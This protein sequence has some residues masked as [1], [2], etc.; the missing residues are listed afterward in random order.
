LLVFTTCAVGYQRRA[1]QMVIMIEISLAVYAASH[2]III[3]VI[4]RGVLYG[5]VAVFVF[6][7]ILPQKEDVTYI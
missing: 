2:Q 4:K 7:L 5:A 6:Y 3:R 1:A